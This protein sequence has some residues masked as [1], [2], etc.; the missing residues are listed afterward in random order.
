MT[1]PRDK[2][3]TTKPK[4]ILY[5]RNQFGAVSQ[6]QVNSLKES[7]ELTL[8][9]I[10]SCGSPGTGFIDKGGGPE[11]RGEIEVVKSA[12]HELGEAFA[13]R[14]GVRGGVRG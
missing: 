4:H 12:R 8:E 6:F 9:E 14:G 7:E 1:G 2:N 10:L 5:S 11:Q 13:V 3:S